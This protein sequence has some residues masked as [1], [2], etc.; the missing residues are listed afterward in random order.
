MSRLDDGRMV[1][2]IGHVFQM[3]NG[4]L[5][6][7]GLERY[8]RMCLEIKGPVNLII[9]QSTVP[10]TEFI[11]FQDGA[12]SLDVMQIRQL[13]DSST[14]ADERY[15]PSNARQEVRK[16]DTRDMY[17][18][19]RKEYRALK[20]RRPRMGDVWYSEQIAKMDIA[21]ERDSETIRKQMVK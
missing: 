6:H 21:N 17:E 5:R 14:T 19:W 7:A 16:L 2:G 13:V 11:E 12:Y 3:I 10:L 1:A 9:G 18:S 15:T 8:G 4:L 20:K